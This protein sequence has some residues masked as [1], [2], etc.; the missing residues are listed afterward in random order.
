MNRLN[1]LRSMILSLSVVFATGYGELALA[2][3]PMV[4]TKAPGYY[5]MMLG[6][7]EV[8]ALSDGTVQLPVDKLLKTPAVHTDE[9]LA[10]S[11]LGSPLDVSVNAFLIN[12]GSKLILIDSG[13]AG[14]FGPTLGKVLANLKA[15]GY[16]PEQVDDVFLTHIHPDHV[17]GLLSNGTI[18]FPNATVHAEKRDV[19]FWVSA[20]H[21]QQAAPADKG[22]YQGAIAS[23]TPY[24][25]AQKLATFDGDTRLEKGITAI[26]T[27]GHTVGHTSYLIE[28]EGHTMIVVGDLIHVAEVQFPEPNIAIDFDTDTKEAIASR[29]IIFDQIV[30]EGYWV[31][32]AHLSFPGLGHLNRFGG[33]YEFVPVNY[34]GL[35]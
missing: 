18:A 2:A 16:Q 21:M 12:T 17:G 19:D 22:F 8:T 28:S 31:A 4:K 5:R 33:G 34:Q 15:S 29:R 9:V 26:S 20:D 32:A 7:F 10:R 6:G 1:M 35:P 14:L 13:A 30:K 23:L 27:P 11:Y 3:A 25:N 24:I